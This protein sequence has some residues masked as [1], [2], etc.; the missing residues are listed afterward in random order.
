MEDDS[1][2]KKPPKIEA[3][4][5]GPGPGCYSLPPTIGFVNH[6]YT[7]FASPAY[8]FRQRLN[9]HGHNASPGP[10]YYVSPE[11][12]RF[13]RMKG[14]SYSM[15]GRAKPPAFSMLKRLQKPPRAF[16]TPGPGAHSPEKVSIHKTGGP[17][18]SFG[19]RHSE[20]L[21]PFMADAPEW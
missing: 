7:R 13:G 21:M 9:N 20:Y 18:Y 17:S 19:V 5:P 6:D 3:L 8:S 4:E 11:H 12:T 16:Q 10:C 1:Q 14:P 2:L 15:L